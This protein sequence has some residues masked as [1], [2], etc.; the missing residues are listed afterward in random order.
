ME[1]NSQQKTHWAQMSISPWSGARGFERLMG[2][3]YF[4]VLKR[5]IT[6]TLGLNSDKNTDYMEKALSKSCLEL[7]FLQ[8]SQ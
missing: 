2:L 6:V 3:K 4:Y 1:L 5:Q 8:T 7:H